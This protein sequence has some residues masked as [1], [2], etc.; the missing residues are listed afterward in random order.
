LWCLD[1]LGAGVRGGCRTVWGRR[2][3]SELLGVSPRASALGSFGGVLGWFEVI[4][5]REAIGHA[6]R[7]LAIAL[8]KAGGVWA[9]RSRALPINDREHAKA[10][11][12]YIARHASQGCAIYV[13]PTKAQ[14]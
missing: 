6:K 3:R 7:R 5:P 10:A 1:E 12:A 4:D 11:R 2:E 8:S 13:A 14:G 9:V